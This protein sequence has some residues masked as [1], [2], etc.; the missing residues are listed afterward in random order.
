MAARP[1][2]L[3][4]GADVTGWNMTNKYTTA[5]VGS[6]RGPVPGRTADG[7]A[8]AGNFRFSAPAVMMDGRG[9]DLSLALNY[10][11][12]VWH[13]A[14]SE[15]TF[16]ID[17][18]LI[19]GWNLGFGK[20]VM[21]GDTYFLMSGD[22][23]RHP[24]IGT[25]HYSFPA[26]ME[27]IQTYEAYTTDGTFIHYY[28]E[29]YEPQFDNSGGKN[30]ITAWAVMPDGTRIEYGAQANYAIYPV[31][32]TDAHGNF[33][34]ITYRNNEGPHIQTITDTLGRVV[35]F[36]YDG[37]GLLTAISVPGLGGST[38][39]AVRLQYQSLTLGNAGSNYG[40]SSG[41]TTKVRQGTIPMIKAIYYPG[42]NTG[43]WF[44][45]GD[46]YSPYGMIRKVSE[47]RGMTFDNA[48]LN[49]QGSIGAGVMSREIVYNYPQSGTIRSPV[50]PTAPCRPTRR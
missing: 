7:G 33:I 47:R 9:I 44:G 5:D 39:V 35:Q 29:G 41:L 40:F 13:R 25:A 21:A 6:E 16:D 30:L 19:P 32:I 37:S 43:Y 26:P 45:D 3:A 46:S 1:G 49:Q 23:T 31:R 15:I 42:T 48:P 17:R 38:R 14:N 28:A 2:L 4:A 11:S 12:R 10:N 24:H 27:S 36:H 18:D 50:A 20:I 34:N 8:G 22:G